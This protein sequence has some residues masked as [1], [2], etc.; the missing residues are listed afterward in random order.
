[1]SGQLHVSGRMKDT[2]S[3][4][5]IDTSADNRMTVAE[6]ER[7]FPLLNIVLRSGHV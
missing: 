5:F 4:E 3:P 6:D 2:V 7:F 1:M